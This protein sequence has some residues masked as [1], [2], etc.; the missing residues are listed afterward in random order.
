MSPP[1]LSLMLLSACGGGDPFERHPG[2]LESAARVETHGRLVEQ[3]YVRHGLGEGGGDVYSVLSFDGRPVEIEGGHLQHLSFCE[4]CDATGREAAA[5]ILLHRDEAVR[6]LYVYQVVDGRLQSTRICP[7]TLGL[8]PW[9]GMR[10]SEA[11]CKWGYYDAD[12]ST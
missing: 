4:T 1:L 12:I 8:E 5:A 7:A 11:R 3:E 10:Y 6:G 9:K 2:L